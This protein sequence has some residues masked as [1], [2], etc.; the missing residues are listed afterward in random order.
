MKTCTF[1]GHR[2]CPDDILPDLRHKIIYLI[3]NRN[4][5]TFY[6]GNQGNFDNMVIKIFKELLPLY[7]N[8]NF[9][10]VLAYIPT[11]KGTINDFIATNSL[12]PENIETV[13]KKFAITYRNKWLVEHS[14]IFVTYITRPFGGAAQFVALAERKQKEI[15]NSAQN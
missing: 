3:E 12:I 2:D 13:P 4:V 11:N 14:D 6:V 1:F 15:I 9:H 10:V 5:K 8:I 7:S